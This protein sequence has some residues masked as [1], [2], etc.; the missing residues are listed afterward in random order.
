MCSKGSTTKL[1]QGQPNTME[2]RFAWLEALVTS[3]ATQVKSTTSGLG[4]VKDREDDKSYG[5]NANQ[6]FVC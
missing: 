5:V 3:M 2:A 4:K 1:V 6:I